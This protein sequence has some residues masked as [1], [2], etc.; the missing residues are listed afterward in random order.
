MYTKF[1]TKLKEKYSSKVYKIPI[2]IDTTCPV[3]D[4]SISKG[5]CIFCGEKGAGYENG[6]CKESITKQINDNLDIF[7]NKYKAEKFI[8]YFQNFTNTYIKLSTF[9]NNIL[10]AVNAVDNAVAISISTRPDCIDSDYL[11]FLKEVENKYHLDIIIELGLQSVNNET[12]KKLNRGHTLADYLKA[13]LLIKSYDFEICTHI[14]A[15]IP[16]DRDEDLV[17]A[18]KILSILNTNSVKIHSLYIEKNTILGKMYEEGKIEMLELDDFVRRVVLFLEN[19]SE[20]IAVER[21][22]SRVPKEEDVLF[23]NWDR[24]HWVIQDMI[25]DEMKK[26]NTYQGKKYKAYEKGLLDKFK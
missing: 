2:S 4:G 1:S 15:S 22:V 3:R 19:L 10:E 24:S 18:A 20:D 6:D 8:L 7:V 16:Y 17:E 25:I 12:L 26:Q 14:I 9:K 21:L 23:L 13:A 5:G 11:D